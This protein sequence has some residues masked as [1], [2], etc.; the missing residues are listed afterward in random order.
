MGDETGKLGGDGTPVEC[1][2][3]FIGPNPQKMHKK[4]RIEA[5]AKG[6]CAPVQN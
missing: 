2:E 3:T 1:D 4:K 5:N 6:L